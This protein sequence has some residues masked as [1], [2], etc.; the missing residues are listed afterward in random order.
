MSEKSWGYVLLVTRAFGE[1]VF[2]FGVAVR[3]DWDDTDREHGRDLCCA[4]GTQSYLHT[5][6]DDSAVW[7]LAP[8]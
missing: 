8:R 1:A 5:G 4:A 3:I 7:R 2:Y 6:C